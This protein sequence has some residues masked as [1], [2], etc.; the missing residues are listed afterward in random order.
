MKKYLKNN[1]GM[2]LPMV[3]IIM[4]ILMTFFSTNSPSI[5]KS[6]Y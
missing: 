3:L 5:K 4:A 2:A 1:E 6:L